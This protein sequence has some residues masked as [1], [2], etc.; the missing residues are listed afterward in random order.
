MLF[1]YELWI[2]NNELDWLQIT[3]LRQACC[4]LSRCNLSGCFCYLAQLMTCPRKYLKN[5]L[6]LP[7]LDHLGA[8]K[9]A[10]CAVAGSLKQIS[11]LTFS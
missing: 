5:Q 4:K 7:Y 10:T 2:N 8:R 3:I 6:P 9:P 1:N 11:G